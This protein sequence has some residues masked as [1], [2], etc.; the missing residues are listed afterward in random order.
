MFS[1][2][3]SVI[4]LSAFVIGNKITPC[5]ICPVVAKLSFDEQQTR[6]KDNGSLAVKR[7]VLT[8]TL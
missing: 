6:V 1:I 4:S 2:Y 5:L 7:V 8:E 3:M